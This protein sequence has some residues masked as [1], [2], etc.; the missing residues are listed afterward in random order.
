MKMVCDV[1]LSNLHVVHGRVACAGRCTDC[2]LGFARHLYLVHLIRLATRSEVTILSS[3]SIL[4]AH[5]VHRET[6]V[7]Q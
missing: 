4:L 1:E 5:F 2:A 7:K 3:R 6:S